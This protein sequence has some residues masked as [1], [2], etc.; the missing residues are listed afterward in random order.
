[1]KKLKKKISTNTIMR[2]RTS[3]MLCWV[4]IDSDQYTIP[5]RR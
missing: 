3:C 5:M 1:M 2:F 4:S